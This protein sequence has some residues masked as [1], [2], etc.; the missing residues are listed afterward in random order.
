MKAGEKANE[1]VNKYKAIPN[2]TLKIIKD[3][4][5]HSISIASVLIF[6]NEIRSTNVIY[7]DSVKNEV[8]KLK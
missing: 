2:V 7:W 1:L 3:D 5:V 8:L 6:I 4:I